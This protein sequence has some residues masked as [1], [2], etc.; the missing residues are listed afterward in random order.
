MKDGEHIGYFNSGEI[1]YKC[2]YLGGELHGEYIC[3]Y[4]SGEISYKIN[5]IDGKRHGEF[6]AYYES[7]EVDFKSYDIN[8]EGV[9]ELEWLSYNRNIKFELLVL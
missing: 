8:G 2:N 4:I 9:T 7:G 5:F 3:Y 6:T 1:K